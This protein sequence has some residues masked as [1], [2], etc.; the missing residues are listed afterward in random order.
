MWE[1]GNWMKNLGAD[2]S[3]PF[4]FQFQISIFKGH[5]VSFVYLERILKL[6]KSCKNS[7]QPDTS[8]ANMISLKHLSVGG[9]HQDPVHLSVSGRIS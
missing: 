9:T 1:V 7:P 4:F 5:K 8:N 2:L 6:Q 3:F